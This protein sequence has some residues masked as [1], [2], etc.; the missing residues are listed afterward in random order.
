MGTAGGRDFNA[1][2]T[3]SSSV[4]RPADETVLKDDFVVA[5]LISAKHAR[6]SA[7]LVSVLSFANNVSRD[8]EAP[9]FWKSE[10]RKD[11]TKGTSRDSCIR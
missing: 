11:M 4:D 3:I 1:V 8:G 7:G 10:V 9:F 6:I 2:A 5:V